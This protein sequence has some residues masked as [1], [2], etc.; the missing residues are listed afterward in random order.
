M[1]NPIP[2]DEQQKVLQ[3]TDLVPISPLD[4]FAPWTKFKSIVRVVSGFTKR[5]G[6]EIV[7]HLWRRVDGSIDVHEG[8]G[9]AEI[10][11]RSN[12]AEAIKIAARAEA[13]VKNAEAEKVRAEA[14]KVRA[15]AEQTRARTAIEV[16]KAQKELGITPTLDIGSIT[17]RAA[18]HNRYITESSAQKIAE[19]LAETLRVLR[20][21]GHE[22]IICEQG[23]DGEV[24][25]IDSPS[26]QDEI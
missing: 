17:S 21:Y 5:P 13:K 20:K 12:E 4:L 9:Q 22:V 3:R 1:N 15:E 16:A 11:K 2:E 10:E 24:K 7:A 8:I 14:G 18:N 19:D 23:N 25:L 26:D 6:W